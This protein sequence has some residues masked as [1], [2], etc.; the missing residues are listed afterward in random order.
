MST[1]ATFVVPEPEPE[2]E[3]DSESESELDP[4]FVVTRRVPRGWFPIFLPEELVRIILGYFNYGTPRELSLRDV[5]VADIHRATVHLALAAGCMPEDI[6]CCGI[7]RDVLLDLPPALNELHLDRIYTPITLRI[8]DLTNLTSVCVSDICHRPDASEPVRGLTKCVS[9]EELSVSNLSGDGWLSIGGL[10]NL[11]KLSVCDVFSP[12][13]I[14]GGENLTRVNISRVYRPLSISGI[15]GGVLDLRINFVSGDYDFSRF[16]CSLSRVSMDVLT[17]FD[18]T[19]LGK[20]PDDLRDLHIFSSDGVI[21]WDGF[22][23]S[24]CARGEASAR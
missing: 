3:S 16:P 23:A 8:F 9:I 6:S 11:K 24:G 12:V 1:L 5:S 14:E 15:N 2:P 20:L 7:Y 17:S 4:N 10:P 19:R 22:G 13:S 18:L 21:K